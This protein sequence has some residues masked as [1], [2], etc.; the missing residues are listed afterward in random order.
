[1]DRTIAEAAARRFADKID[2]EFSDFSF[3]ATT[4]ASNESSFDMNKF[5]EMLDEG[6]KLVRNARRNQLRF[7]VSR[8]HIG[9]AL[10][11]KH[12]IDGSTLECSYEQARVIHAEWPL[13]FVEAVDVDTALF[14]PAPQWEGHMFIP[15]FPPPYDLPED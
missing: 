8:G 3:G 14:R 2:R 10:M 15:L 4:T 1:M 13:E 12:P 6:T 7:Q 11:S 9:P 5:R